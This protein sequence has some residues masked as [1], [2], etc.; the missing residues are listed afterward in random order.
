MK[1]AALFL[2]MSMPAVA[3]PVEPQTFAGRYLYVGGEHEKHLLD[4]AIDAVVSKMNVFIRPIA[5]SKMR[6]PN[7]PSPELF[8]LVSD[9]NIT[10]RRP[11]RPEVTAPA[12]GRA[13]QWKHPNSGDVFTVAHGVVDGMLYQRFEDSRAHSLNRFKLDA[14]KGILIVETITTSKYFPV[15]LHFAMTYQRAP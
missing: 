8:V 2:A 11:G 7:Q 9:G 12:D 14:A 10:V 13:I 15:P 1:L 5:R 6:G 4:A 3:E